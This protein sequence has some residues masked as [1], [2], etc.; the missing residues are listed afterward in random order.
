MA[1]RFDNLE[2][3]GQCSPAIRAQLEAQLKGYALAQ[4]DGI[5]AVKDGKV[6]TRE[7]LELPAPSK[8]RARPE[9]DAGEALVQ[10]MQLLPPIAPW[11]I[12]PWEVFYHVPNGG[13]RNPIEARIFYGQGV[14]AGWPDYGLDLPLG[15]YHGMRLELKAGANK[16]GPEQ[17]EILGHLERVGYY[18]RV[19]WG[20]EEARDAFEY[21][22][23]L[24]S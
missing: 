16:P 5:A 9:Q 21:Y 7:D 13:F 3:L 14:R 11:G 10:W 6:L 17:L 15:G 1:L 22:L 8:K 19:A 12:K 4:R 23:A 2:Q 20:F 18:V 24:R